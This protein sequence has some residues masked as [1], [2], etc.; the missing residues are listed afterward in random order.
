MEL[1]NLKIKTF[2]Y[3]SKKCISYIAGNGIFSVDIINSIDTFSVALLKE[4][5]LFDF[6]NMRVLAILSRFYLQSEKFNNLIIHYSNV[7]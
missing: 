6:P 1:F 3:L 7:K 2:F 5:S 4:F